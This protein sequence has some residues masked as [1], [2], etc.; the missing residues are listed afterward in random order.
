MEINQSDR[1]PTPME[2]PA[3][4]PFAPAI[5]PGIQGQSM[6][7]PIIC[8]ERRFQE[9]LKTLKRNNLLVYPAIQHLIAVLGENPLDPQ[10]NQFLA[11]ILA[12]IRMQEEQF[13]INPFGDPPPPGALAGEFSLGCSSPDAPLCRHG[14]LLPELAQNIIIAG[15]Q[16]AGKSNLLH[17]IVLHN[18]ENPQIRFTIM[19]K[20]P[21]ER[22]LIKMTR[23]P[24]IV[25]TK[26]DP[27][28]HL[29][30][31]GLPQDRHALTTAMD[32]TFSN[33]IWL[34]P[35]AVLSEV[36]Q[37]LS[38]K[39]GA[40][41]T[42]SEV[43]GYIKAMRK[44]DRAMMAYLA[45]LEIKIGL[46][47]RAMRESVNC[48]RGLDLRSTI[49]FHRIIELP[50]DWPAE[51]RRFHV[52]HILSWEFHFRRAWFATLTEEEIQKVPFAVFVID[53]GHEYFCE[54]MQQTRRESLP[55]FYELF[56]GA[57]AYKMAFIIATHTPEGLSKVL[58]GCH[59]TTL[60]L[61]LVNQ[62]G[63]NR[64]AEVL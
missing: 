57:R 38:E 46:L 60:S 17:N 63:R 64:V 55:P 32:F 49:G 54:E 16:G 53:D 10:A 21:D 22:G 50:L 42:W 5:P 24:I 25:V 44:S 37:R 52:Q 47:I 40:P 23:Q 7:R 11:L 45:S 9:A 15:I 48:R 29:D 58:W 6:P 28:N 62:L 34:G 35:E 3:T 26:T 61:R 4:T 33:R 41:P 12:R 30:G 20:K 39:I 43:R 59:G 1:S 19:T 36:I 51:V 13:G 2:L 31:M 14:L 27:I 18:L 8:D 56:T